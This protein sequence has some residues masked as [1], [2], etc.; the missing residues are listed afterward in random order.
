MIQDLDSPRVTVDRLCEEI[1]LPRMALVEQKFDDTHLSETEIREAIRQEMSRPV[2]REQ[3]KPGQRIAIT[4][5]SRGVAN[6]RLITQTIVDFVKEQ[7]ATP[8]VFPAMGSH[9]GATAEGQL[10]VLE[11]FGITEEFLGCPILASMETVDVGVTPSGLPVFMDKYASEAD[12]VIVAG[13]IKPHTAFRGKYESG[14]LKMSVIGMGKQHGAESIHE[15]GF[16]KMAQ[17]LA[18]AGELVLNKVNI[19]CGVGTIENAFDDTYKVVALT[20][21]EILLEEPTLLDEA[22]SLMGRILFDDID[23]LIVDEIGKD[24]SGDGMDPNVTGRFPVPEAAS[25]GPKIQRVIIRDIT[26]RTHGNFNGLGAAD[27]I[28]RRCFDR[29]DVDETYPNGVTSTVLGV[30]HIPVVVRREETAFKMAI[31]TC[32]WIDKENPRIV[33]IRNTAELEEIWISEALLGEARA[34][35]QLTVKGEP[36]Y[37]R[38]AEDGSLVE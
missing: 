25:G 24:I 8:F 7:G 36:E 5:G 19:I 13:R 15:Q 26:D 27:I 28:T 12:A 23:L 31:K 32:N 4:A 37:M 35:P 21:E 34:N 14:L 29:L 20:P 3:I 6:V 2:I 16:L 9:G 22:K 33:R 11:R 38:F 30:M 18:E 17:N 1:R 10:G